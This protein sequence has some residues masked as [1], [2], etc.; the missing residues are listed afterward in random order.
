MK[1]AVKRLKGGENWKDIVNSLKT[2]SAKAAFSEHIS[3]HTQDRI[4][5]IE[6]ARATDEADT[7][8]SYER[9]GNDTPASA[10]KIAIRKQKEA[11]DGVE[12]E[13][14]AS[15]GADSF[16][17]LIFRNS[18]FKPGE[19]LASDQQAQLLASN[20]FLVKNGWLDDM[21]GRLVETV[22]DNKAGKLSGAA[23]EEADY[24]EEV[25]VKQ[26]HWGS[27]MI[28]EFTNNQRII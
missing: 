6:K 12:T 20:Q 28:K 8:W 7:F 10:A 1:E 23:K 3:T 11:Y 4:A 22:K 13:R 16:K 24:L 18:K 25:L 19:Q 17:R 27:I 26:L 21:L 9:T 15:M 2:V 14:G 5:G